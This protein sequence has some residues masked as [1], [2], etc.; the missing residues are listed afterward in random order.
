MILHLATQTRDT[1]VFGSD[2]GNWFRVFD[3]TF[4]DFDD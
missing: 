4:E 3:G 2:F 1:F